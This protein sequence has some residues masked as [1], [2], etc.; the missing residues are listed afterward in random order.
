MS[1]GMQPLSKQ[2]VTKSVIGFPKS[3]QNFFYRKW[4]GFH[5]PKT[6]HRGHSAQNIFEFLVRNRV[7]NT[8]GL[9]RGQTIWA[10]EVWGCMAA[11][12]IGK[13]NLFEVSPSH[14]FK[15]FFFIKNPL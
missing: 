9:G 1:S 10:S 13:E 2:V 8:L 6:L 14:M 3:S 7:A 11:S 12:M 4:P 5:R 15:Q